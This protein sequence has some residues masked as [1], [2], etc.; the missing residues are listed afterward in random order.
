MSEPSTDPFGNPNPFGEEVQE[1]AK[2]IPGFKAGIYHLTREYAGGVRVKFIKDPFKWNIEHGTQR[3]TRK[4]IGK[5]RVD[6]IE[7]GPHAGQWIWEVYGT[8]GFEALN[9]DYT[10]TF[11]TARGALFAFVKAHKA[12]LEKRK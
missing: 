6:V 9:T 4:V 2:K 10:P 12:Y 8:R 5:L 11:S 3:D 7:K 1:I